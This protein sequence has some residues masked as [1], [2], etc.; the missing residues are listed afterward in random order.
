[1][2]F[3]LLIELSRGIDLYLRHYPVTGNDNNN[4]RILNTLSRETIQRRRYF[5]DKI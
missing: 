5:E 4:S 3:A 2:T 1:M